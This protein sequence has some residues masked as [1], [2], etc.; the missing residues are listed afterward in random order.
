[1]YVPTTPVPTSGY[2]LLV[3]EEDVTELDWSPE[4]ALQTIISAGLTAPPEVRYFK[5][6]TAPPRPPRGGPR[7]ETG[8]LP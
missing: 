6:G 4:Q 1:V 7:E 3:P 5:P 2:F 8:G